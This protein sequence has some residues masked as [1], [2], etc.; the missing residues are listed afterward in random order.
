M[1]TNDSTRNIR[2]KDAKSNKVTN[3]VM[4]QTANVANIRKII[5]TMSQTRSTFGLRRV[6]PTIRIMLIGITYPQ[7][8]RPVIQTYR[9]A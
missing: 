9:I 2:A 1:I 3:T 5:V 6:V 4:P 8:T 7:Y